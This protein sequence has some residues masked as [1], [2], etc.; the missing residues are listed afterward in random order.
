MISQYVFL[1][2]VLIV[3]AM[4]LSIGW[5]NSEVR[6]LAFARKP[7]IDWTHYSGNLEYEDDDWQPLRID[8]SRD[9]VKRRRYSLGA[10][11]SYSLNFEVELADIEPDRG[12]FAGRLPIP[13]T[14]NM[15]GHPYDHPDGYLLYHAHCDFA[16]QLIVNNGSPALRINHPIT[17]L[18]R[19]LPSNAQRFRIRA[20]ATRIR[21]I[22]GF[23]SLPTTDTT[24]ESRWIEI[25]LGRDQFLVLKVT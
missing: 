3:V 12:N 19:E 11:S 23:L 16:E 17:G 18:T 14:V 21:P 25:S 10:T 2:C 13:I 1:A 8:G 24:E 7:K 5:T 15:G 6:R 22:F 4:L 20:K 9:D